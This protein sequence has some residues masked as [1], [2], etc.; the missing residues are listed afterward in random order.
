MIDHFASAATCFLRGYDDLGLE[1]QTDW[2]LP[3]AT[4]V[5]PL[6]SQADFIAVQRTNP[7]LDFTLPELL[8]ID[9]ADEFLRWVDDPSQRPRWMRLF[10]ARAELRAMELDGDG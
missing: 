2:R 8:L 6:I 1:R 9:V 4:K 5:R 10:E 3:D 7:A